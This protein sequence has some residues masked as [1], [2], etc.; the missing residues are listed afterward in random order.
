MNRVVG[1]PPPRLPF[2]CRVTRRAPCRELFERRCKCRSTRY[3]R[4]HVERTRLVV[5]S[6][7]RHERVPVEGANECPCG[8]GSHVDSACTCAIGTVPGLH[9][10]TQLL[11]PRAS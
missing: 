2:D 4:P 6:W 5:A 7:S 9:Q 11:L 1:T 3:R 8:D 10:P